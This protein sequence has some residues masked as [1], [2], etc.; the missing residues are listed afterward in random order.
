M[1]YL[2]LLVLCISS[3]FS[4]DI[5]SVLY[6]SCKFCH[7]INADKIYVNTIPSIK[8]LDSNTLKTKLRLY[9]K[10]K[11]DLYGY[12]PIMEQQMKNIP[13]DKIAILVNYIK[14]L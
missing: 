4:K 6:S 12:G 1:K 3:L 10:G 2:F 11:L 13:N 8:S 9:K 7:G 14:T 5:G